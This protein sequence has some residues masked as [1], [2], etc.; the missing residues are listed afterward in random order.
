MY[1]VKQL[2]V[3][4]TVKEALEWLHQNPQAKVIAGGTDLLLK[5]RN[6]AMREVVLVSL[7][8]LKELEGIEILPDGTLRIGAM[9][10]FTQVNRSSL[11]REKLPFLAE[12]AV[13]MGGPQIQNVATIGGN[14]CNG[15]V[16]A[17][18][19]P[20]LLAL[21][22][23]LVLENREGTREVS[24]EDFYLGPGRVDLKEDELLTAIKIP[25]PRHNKWGGYYYKYS[26]RRAMDIST[27]GCAVVCAVEAGGQVSQARIALGTAAPTPIRCR[28]AEALVAG[29]FLS[30]DLLIRI[31]ETAAGEAKPRSSWR[32]SKE[33]RLELIKELTA[34]TL[35]QAYQ[36]AGGEYR[37]EN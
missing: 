23:R 6:Q 36:N 3:P 35:V 25:L 8:K 9:V 29:R 15:A 37:D 2:F 18:S 27:L 31:G 24:L 16:S 5:M 30:P 32:A 21:E 14:L 20:S 33:F 34:R 17:D 7:H 22:A 12:A 11:V 19:A 13:T 1:G 26:M 28:Q 4:A 10:T